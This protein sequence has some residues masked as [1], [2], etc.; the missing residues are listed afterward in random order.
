MHGLDG[1]AATQGAIAAAT[2]FGHGLALLVL[3]PTASTRGRLAALLV[4]AAG[5][6]L[7]AGSLAAAAFF[8]TPT[9]AAPAGGLL[10]MAGWVLLAVDAVRSPGG[11]IVCR[12]TL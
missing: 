8:A 7:F 9:C 6:V 5:L 3:A 11:S 4:L 10:L 1:H 12:S 2:A